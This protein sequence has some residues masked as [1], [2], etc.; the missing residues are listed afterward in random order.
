MLPD[1]LHPIVVHF[2][3]VLVVL[4]PVFALGAL[5][6]IR[7]GAAARPVWALPLA[8]AAA[9]TL[10]AW[11]A[12]QTGEQEEDRVERIVGEAALHTHE[13]AAER[14]LVLSAVLLVVAGVGMAG[15]TAGSAA[16]MVATV[17]SLGLVLAGIQV[18]GTGGDLVYR[19][20]AASAYQQA[21]TAERP[22]AEAAE[23]AA[24]RR[25]ARDDD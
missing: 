5:L 12:I 18:G 9:L 23:R 1:P 10:S 13:E 24:W 21:S 15:G 8:V 3:V 17:G 6:V 20:G 2:P 25:P 14:F 16:R 19:H 22:V 7:R 4:L 11:V